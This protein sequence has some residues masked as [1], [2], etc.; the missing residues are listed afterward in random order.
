M[1]RNGAD[2]GLGSVTEKQ[3]WKS[4]KEGRKEGRVGLVSSRC[5]FLA[6]ASLYVM[7]SATPRALHG[8]SQVIF[9]C[10]FKIL[11]T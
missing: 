10:V 3:C 6:F 4:L 11:K 7:T 8:T 1:Q 2:D 5:E 9:T